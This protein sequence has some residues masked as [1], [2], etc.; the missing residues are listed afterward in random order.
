M[1]PTC[2]L[3]IATDDHHQHR[4]RGLSVHHYFLRTP[5]ARPRRR[6]RVI[7]A[8]RRGFCSDG[9][10]K[11]RLEFSLCGREQRGHSRPRRPIIREQFSRRRAPQRHTLV[12]LAPSLSRQ[13]PAAR[14]RRRGRAPPIAG[15]FFFFSTSGHFLCGGAIAGALTNGPRSREEEDAV[16]SS[17]RH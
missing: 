17:R 16:A 12:Q 4:H 2:F 5:P 15:L 14:L 13:T 11:R 9:P 10:N 3:I 1:T 7:T 8:S 6:H